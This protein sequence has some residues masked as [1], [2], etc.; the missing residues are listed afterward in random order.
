[1]AVDS[2]LFP[3]FVLWL[4]GILYGGCLIAALRM[5]PWTRF[6]DTEQLHVFLV[7]P[8]RNLDD[9]LVCVA[10]GVL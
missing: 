3:P 10:G 8:L 1:M 5:A 9:Y 2:T 7:P 4:V 6:R